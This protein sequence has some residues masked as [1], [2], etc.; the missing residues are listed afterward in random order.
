MERGGFGRGVG[1]CEGCCFVDDGVVGGCWVK[2]WMVV[3]DFVVKGLKGGRRVLGSL[4]EVV[5]ME[6][7]DAMQKFQEFEKNYFKICD[8]QH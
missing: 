3:D 8:V 1:F 6:C 5:S 4:K 7:V 2:L